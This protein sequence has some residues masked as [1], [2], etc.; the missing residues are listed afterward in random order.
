MV[1]LMFQSSIVSMNEVDTLAGDNGL[2]H[3]LRH[4]WLASCHAM[5]DYYSNAVRLDVP[6]GLSFVFWG[7]NYL[8]PTSLISFMNALHLINK[9]NKAYLAV[10][11]DVKAAMPSLDQVHV[12]K[13]ILDIFPE[14]LHRMPPNREIEFCIDLV[15]GIQLVSILPYRMALV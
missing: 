10:V 4:D 7:Y 12:V 13:D 15:F 5:V 11:R 1:Q 9:G 14:E 2:R 3:H 8:T 6:N